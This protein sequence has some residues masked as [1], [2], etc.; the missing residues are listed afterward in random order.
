MKKII[1][2][3]FALVITLSV[4]V[5]TQAAGSKFADVPLNHWAQK[6]IE[7]FAEQN[8]V[9]GVSDGTF[10]P[11]SGVSREQFCKMLVLTFNAAMSSPTSPSFSDVDASKWSYQYVE[12]S[13]DFLTGYSNPF[14][15]LPAFHPEEYA[16]REDIAVALVRMMG[17]TEADANDKNYAYYKFRDGSSISPALLG[18]VSVACEKGLI[19]GYTDGSFGP[20]RGISRAETVVLLNRAAK[21]A[22][23][24]IGQELDVSASIVYSK[25]GKTA[26]IHVE[27]ETGIAVTVNGEKIKMSNNGYDRYEGVFSHVFTEEGKKD[28]V[29]TAIKSGKTKTINLTA[30]YEIGA[31]VL[32]ITQCPSTVEKKEI[33]IEGTIKDNANDISLT[34]NGESVE[35]STYDGSWRKTFDIEEGVNTFVIEGKN[36]AGKT[37]TETRTVTCKLSAPTLTITECPT[38]VTTRQITIKGTLKDKNYSSSL[39]I[40]GESVRLDQGYLDGRWSA[41]FT[42]KEGDN[43]FIIVGTNAAGKSVTETR[44]VTFNAGG[45]ILTITECPITVTSKYITIKGTLNDSNYSTSLTINGES[46]SRQEGYLDGRWSK[47][48]TLEEGE[49]T[50]VIVGT[51]AV[52]K[53]VTETRT[54][55][56]NV[57]SLDILFS[58]CPEITQQK[59]LSLQGTI[60]GYT[61]GIKLYIN[62]QQAT[63][64]SSNNFAKTV[65]LNEGSNTFIF[66]VVNGFGK[67]TTVV[68]TIKYVTEITPPA[69][70]VDNVPENVKET[71][72]IISGTVQDSLDVGAEVYVNDK[73]VAT[74]N[75]PWSTS[76]SLKEGN[77]IIVITATNSFG[78]SVTITKSVSYVVETP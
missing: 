15:G 4:S 24:T 35:I 78:K 52:G 63:L 34:I 53:S 22:V 42:L 20:T 77:N 76:V 2:F 61:D 36:S 23:T 56:F 25:D 38:T 31:P 59:N 32:S 48:F 10:S 60:S 49:N 54:V 68:K 27:G 5:S 26:T 73:K 57:G 19:T 8:I 66:R 64:D 33:T 18:Y 65:T 51:N 29:I 71:A 44:T 6:E 70:T 37:V 67:S 16:T 45:P 72:L 21:Q 12:T 75:G 43:T 14:G 7:Y 30:K 11:D 69:L 1:T 47:S 3:I 55:T 13:K 46:V 58:N 9:N 41:S 40:N 74:G 50:F 39:T 17:L 28:F 62:D